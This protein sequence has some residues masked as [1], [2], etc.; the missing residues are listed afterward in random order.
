MK[1]ETEK[2][3]VVE[4]RWTG[5]DQ[6]SSRYIDYDRY[7][8]TTEPPRNTSGDIQLSGWLGPNGD[9]SRYAHGEYD[10]KTAA[11]Y[12]IVK[13]L[14]GECRRHDEVDADMELGVVALYR[15]GIYTPMDYEA[16]SNYIFESVEAEG[17]H[18]PYGTI[19][20]EQMAKLVNDLRT[21]LH[22]NGCDASEDRVEDMLI[23]VCEIEMTTD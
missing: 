11:E 19:T 13:M 14:D 4:V 21:L 15:P 18:V 3:Y 8:V 5:P 22:E 20:R 10:V 9:V 12:A 2:Y 7:E 23:D 1:T 17:V 6:M 16:L